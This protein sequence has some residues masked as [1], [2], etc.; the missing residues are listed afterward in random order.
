MKHQIL[1][2]VFLFF[3]ELW[4]QQGSNKR[5]EVFEEYKKAGM[6]VILNNDP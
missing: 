5:V 1:T 4:N 6:S 2:F 3:A